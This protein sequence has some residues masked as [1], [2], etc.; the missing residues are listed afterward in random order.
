MKKQEF[1][2]LCLRLLGIY[3]FVSGLG[4]LPGIISTLLEY[5]NSRFH[6]FVGPSIYICTGVILVVYAGKLSNFIVDFS[7]AEDDEVKLVASENTARLAFIV[8]GIYIFSYVL[9]QLIQLSIEVGLYYVRI[10]EIPSH[11]R[12]T[13]HR[14][15]IL[16]APSI[17]LGI[18]II[19]IIGPDK[20]IKFI[21][22]YDETFKRLKASNK[23][24]E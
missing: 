13:Q 5:P 9:P 15:S 4:S 14:W 23:R 11:L 7:E 6:F 19:L 1:I 21:S 17:E 16:I 18:A 8:L 20:V 24:M 12:G 22:N 3:L 2:I 10:D